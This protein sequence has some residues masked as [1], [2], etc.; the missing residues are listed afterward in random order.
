[1]TE[2][3]LLVRHTAVAR[4]WAGRC[5]GASDV[6]LSRA[7][8]AALAPL[9]IALGS[10]S[11]VWVMHSGRV[12]TR[13]LAERIASVAQCPLLEDKDWRERNF[14]TWEGE[15]WAAIYRATGNAMDGM[16]DAPATFRPGG[17]ETTLELAAR[18][19]RAW[20]RLPDTMGVVVTHGGP[21]AALVGQLS[22]EPVAAWPG[23]IPAPGGA[24]AVARANRQPEPGA[25]QCRLHAK[26]NKL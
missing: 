5:Y 8:R 25:G 3:P 6:P 20:Q 18:V 17:G 23:L 1:M 16:I 15:S 10:T 2:C 9:A 24:V 13:L 21:I 26:W 4:A 14:G 7:G 11:P 22:G 19:R 12:R